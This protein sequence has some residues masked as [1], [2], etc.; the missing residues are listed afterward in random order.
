MVKTI[1]RQELKEKM[2]RGENL[3]L[4]EA[5]PER[6]YRRAHLPGAVNIPSGRVGELAPRLLPEKDAD[7]VVYCGS[8][9]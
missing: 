1:T 9:R 8:F 3:F 4:V 5:L 7:I 6:L 2:D